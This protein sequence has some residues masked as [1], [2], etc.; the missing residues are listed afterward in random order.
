MLCNLTLNGVVEAIKPLALTPG[1]DFE[2]IA[3][4]F[5]PRELPELA[6]A[7]KWNYLKALGKPEAADGWHFLTS[8]DGQVKILCDEIGFGYK[9]DSNTG[10]YLHQ[11]AIYVVMPDGRVSRTLPGIFYEP[12]LVRDSLAYAAGGQMG[13]RIFRLASS[14]GLMQYDAA[15]GRYRHNPWAWASAIGGMVILLTV[16]TLLATLWRFEAKRRQTSTAPPNEP[17]NA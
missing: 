7:K 17:M 5:N 14:C 9:L 8:K 12:E 3:I 16:G 1:K 13:S 6:K 2:F 15:T 10:Q 4:S 11:A